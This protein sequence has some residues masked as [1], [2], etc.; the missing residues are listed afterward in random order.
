MVQISQQILIYLILWEMAD[1]NYKVYIHTTP[2]NKV[3]IGI[4][5]LL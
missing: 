4:S 3:Y 2:N 5:I 1:K